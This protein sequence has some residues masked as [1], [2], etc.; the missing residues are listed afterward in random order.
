M[1]TTLEEREEG[2]EVTSAKAITAKPSTKKNIVLPARCC[3]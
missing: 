2:G 3:S 1:K